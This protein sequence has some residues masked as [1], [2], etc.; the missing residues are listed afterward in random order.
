MNTDTQ[1]TSRTSNLRVRGFAP[2]VTPAELRRELPLQEHH[3]DVVRAG[4]EAVRAVMNGDDDR[5]VVVIGPCSIHDTEAGLDYARRLQELAE[6]HRDDLVVVMRTYF[7]KPRTTVGWKGLINDPHLDGSHDITAGLRIA[8]Q[9]LIDVTEIGLPTSM[10]FLE[11]ISPQHLADLMS[12]GAIGA[13]T[14]ESQIHRQLTSGLSMPVGFKN[15]TDGSVQVAID[16]CQ[17]SAAAQTFL[18]IDDDGRA[19]LVSTTGN[20]DTHVVLRGGATGPNH[21]P[22]PVGQACAQLAAAGLVPR[23]MIDASHG[24]SGKNHLRQAEV[25]HEIAD[26]VAGG[27]T[28]VAGVMVESFLV[29]GRQDLDVTRAPQEL[30][31][32]Q[33]VTDACLGW[34]MTI[35]VL[36]ALASASAARRKAVAGVG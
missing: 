14:A 27:G 28:G 9:F 30:T 5:L 13:R 34:D 11:P 15:G 23:L 3:G 10:E 7:E 26:Q 25:V 32:G 1:V 22:G 18:G 36:Q 6:R 20:P 8:R 16:G 21:G 24:N 29:G 19:C 12:W 33:S 4:R 17:A 31:Y 2:L 35:D